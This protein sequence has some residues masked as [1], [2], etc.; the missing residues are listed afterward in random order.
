MMNVSPAE[1]PN[2]T[3]PPAPVISSKV[4]LDA[5]VRKALEELCQELHRL[6]VVRHQRWAAQSAH[7]QLPSPM[8]PRQIDKVFRFLE[9]GSYSLVDNSFPTPEEFG[10]SFD[11]DTAPLQRFLRH[12]QLPPVAMVR[13][14][15]FTRHCGRFRD[16]ASWQF[17]FNIDELLRDYW[18]HHDVGFP[19]GLR[20][21][22]AVF[23]AAGIPAEAIGYCRLMI[24][25]WEP[26]FVWDPEAT[27]PYFAEYP[28]LL[29]Q[30][31]DL[32]PTTL[33]KDDFWWRYQRTSRRKLAFDMLAMF[34][35]LPDRFVEPVWEAALGTVKADRPLA[36]KALA[37][38]ADRFERI[39]AALKSGKQDVRAS[40]AEWL[41]R[42]GDPR[43][44]EP[45]QQA[46]AKE[47][48]DVP[49]GAAMAALERL[50]VPVDTFLDR[51]GLL[52]EAEKG[53]ANGVPEDLA[54]FPFDQLPSVHWQDSKKP[55]AP[56]VLKWWIVRTHKL[57]SPEPGVILRRYAQLMRPAEAA[58]LG[59]FVLSAWIACDTRLPSEAEMT[60]KAQQLFKQWSGYGMTYQQA[61][62][63]VQQTPV[64]SAVSTKGI[65]AVAGACCDRRA[66]S[67]V[68]AYL[69]QWYGMRAA[70]CKALIQMLSWIEH[71]A[72]IQLLLG[73]A[74]RFRTAGIRKEAERC[75]NLLAE[76]HDWTVAELADRSLSTC[77]L[78]ENNQLVLDYGPRR[79]IAKLNDDITFAL[80]D[81]DGKPIAALPEPRKDEDAEL[82]K[83]IK[84]RFSDAKK[85]LKTVV[86]QQQERFYEAM[87]EQR[88][89][90]VA[91]WDAYL[92]KHPIV[93]RL[94]QR[95]IWAQVEDKKAVRTFRPLADGTLTDPEDSQVDIPA[96]TCIRVA[97][98]LLVTPEEAALWQ[99]HLADYEVASLFEQFGKPIY[100]LPPET[101]DQTEVRDFL[102]HLIEAFKLR[103]RATKLG[104]VRGEAQDGGWFYRYHK[105]FPTLGIEAQIEFSGNGLPEEN[106]TVALTS[107]AFQRALSDEEARFAGAGRSRVPLSEVPSILLS[108]CWNDMQ[109]IAAQGTGFDPDWEK[110]VNQ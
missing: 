63:N 20:E 35:R 75:V 83:Q 22:A 47:K 95:V 84:K 41:A 88:E 109:S 106:R 96:E 82:V 10:W 21:L 74:R 50:G 104:Y 1:M 32:A 81:A 45:L 18:K 100:Q 72:A 62:A 39:L 92:R 30:A 61:L 38:A 43:A 66:A 27:W 23:A 26:S 36:Q 19:L 65:L 78:D 13:A 69:K 68:G 107:L 7:V 59:L 93:G 99:K 34:P 71:P 73:T 16:E 102:G 9:S 24:W 80:V 25:N 14:L 29:A 108:E 42:L 51:K 86:K 15:I 60:Q 79:F 12:P 44:I 56:E 2:E 49:R 31:L 101:K 94:C 4:E 89:W 48:Y 40:A 46:L 67:M 103:G 70:Q 105:Q 52:Q 28:L 85:E 53:L 55:I 57:K 8:T 54:W 17:S 5:S 98:D 33:P 37:R 87:C 110:K 76:R 58:E 64:G 3:L 6:A 11:E 90:L 91:D 97:H 77:G